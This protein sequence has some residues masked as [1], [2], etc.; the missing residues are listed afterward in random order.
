MICGRGCDLVPSRH[1][2]IEIDTTA[3]YQKSSS[4]TLRNV[5]GAGAEKPASFSQDPPE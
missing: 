4:T 1:A 2:I 5:N 3:A